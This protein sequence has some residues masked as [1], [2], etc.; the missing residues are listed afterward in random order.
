MDKINIKKVLINFIIVVTIFLIDRLSKI[1]ILKKA[2]IESFDN[3]E[4]F[5]KR[6]PITEW[7]KNNTLDC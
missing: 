4:T 6:S 7:E 5:D 3:E 1:Y 2:E